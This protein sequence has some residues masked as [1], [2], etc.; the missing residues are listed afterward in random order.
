MQNLDGLC[1]RCGEHTTA[2]DSCCSEGAIVNGELI[3]DEA[4]ASM[5]ADNTLVEDGGAL[6][7]RNVLASH[8]AWG[9]DKIYAAMNLEERN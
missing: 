2:G 7:M 5:M 4:G 9:L 1:P 8:T 6:A 3:D